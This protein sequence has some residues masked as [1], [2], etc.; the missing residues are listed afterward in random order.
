MALMS[1]TV[2]VLGSLW[3]AATAFAQGPAPSDAG[4]LP[5]G[6]FV[7]T[8]AVGQYAVEAS[9]NG[10]CG[11][12]AAVARSV[13]ESPLG[14]VSVMQVFRAEN[15]RGMRVRFSATVTTNDVTGWA[16]LWMRVD[17]PDKKTLSF[18]NMQNR[19][20]LGTKPCQRASV[21]LEVP[22]S[23]TVIALGLLLHG[24]GRAELSN[25]DLEGVDDTVPTTNLMAMP[26]VASVATDGGTL[27]A[28]NQ[29]LNPT[30]NSVRTPKP[31]G[32]VPAS[33]KRE[34]P[35]DPRFDSAIGRVGNAWFS[36]RI[37]VHQV[38]MNAFSGNE[39]WARTTLNAAGSGELH[40]GPDGDWADRSGDFAASEKG[41]M[42]AAK[43]LVLTDSSD[44]LTSMTGELQLRRDGDFNV[45]EGTWGTLLRK[46]PVSIRYS[47]ERIDMSWGFYERHMVREESPQLA[48]NC[49][50]YSRRDSGRAGRAS[51][52]I[53]LCG[54]VFDKSPPRV[55]TIMVF[56]MSGF[57]RFGTGMALD[58]EPV[59]PELPDSSKR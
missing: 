59:P 39:Q 1:R 8:K 23:A 27:A 54:A 4:A 48:P 21:V 5:Q 7:A 2:A 31:V 37:V 34:R 40:L 52:A 9:P 19:P 58:A 38:D 45:I 13:V 20:F 22:Q 57:R 36:D 43:A 55:Q 35:D 10:A 24:Q 16:G 15:Y 25:L 41:T 11:G 44:L 53:E 46:Y 56:L 6:W 29:V 18:D 12:R 3:L 26:A 32:A 51:D 28:A 33:M 42:V 47:R 50:F 30:T 49:V 17:G 14:E